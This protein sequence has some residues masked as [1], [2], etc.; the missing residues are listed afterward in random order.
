MIQTADIVAARYGI[1]REVRRMNWQP[2]AASSC[3]AARRRRRAGSDDEI[4]PITVH[5]WPSRTR[6]PVKSRCKEVTFGTVMTATAPTP[7]WRGWPALANRCSGEGQFCHRGQCFSQLCDGAAAAGADG[8]SSLAE[9]ERGLD[10]LGAFRGFRGGRM[11]TRR[12]GHRPGLCGAAPAGTARA[13][14]ERYRPVG[15]ERGVCRAGLYCRD[16]LGIDPEKYN[17][18]G[19]SISIGHP[20]RH[21]RCSH[22]RASAARGQAARR[23]ASSSSPCASAAAWARP[24]CS[25][26][27]E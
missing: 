3:T 18:N 2:D 5:P 9:R 12:D 15:A 10:P 7:R 17:V 4:V 14:G 25:R 27:S 23:E 19:G 11:R 8:G 16:T 22:D 24:A 1:S 20:L 26:S 6:K 21:D 13:D